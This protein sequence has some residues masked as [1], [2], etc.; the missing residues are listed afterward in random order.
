MTYHR[1][2]IARTPKGH[3][4]TE[5]VD[6]VRFARRAIR[7]R[8]DQECVVTMAMPTARAIALRVEPVSLSRRIRAAVSI[9]GGLS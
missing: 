8:R 5:D 6:L 4:G 2:I 1:E 7:W 3:I 9:A